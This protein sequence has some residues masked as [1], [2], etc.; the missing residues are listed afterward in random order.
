MLRFTVYTSIVSFCQAKL[1][2]MSV[3]IQNTKSGLAVYIHLYIDVSIFCL[4]VF[5][6]FFLLRRA[7][8]LHFALKNMSKTHAETDIF[9]ARGISWTFIFCE[10]MH[11]FLLKY[12]AKLTFD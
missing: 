6:V 9:F 11:D 7:L 12:P 4:L 3:L 2:L 5:F 1:K 10:C 8:N